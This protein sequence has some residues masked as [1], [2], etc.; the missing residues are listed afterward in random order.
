MSCLSIYDE[1]LTRIQGRLPHSELKNY[2]IK[3]KQPE[4]INNKESYTF[5]GGR[6]RSL[7]YE[8]N[9]EKIWR[10]L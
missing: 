2:D 3:N 7:G 5:N 9:A 6:M 10:N 8:I 4:S 1:V